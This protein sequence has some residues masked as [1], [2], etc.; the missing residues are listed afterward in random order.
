M[1]LLF[2]L[3][4]THYTAD[5]CFLLL[6]RLLRYLSPIHSCA[7]RLPVFL[8]FLRL[9]CRLYIPDVCF[10]WLHMLLLCRLSICSCAGRLQEL[11]LSRYIHCRFL[12]P[13]PRSLLHLPQGSSMCAPSQE[14]YPEFLPHISIYI[15]YIYTF[16]FPVWCIPADSLSWRLPHLHEQ[17][18]VFHLHPDGSYSL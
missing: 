14:A 16:L 5:V 13:V 17:T 7:L 8:L 12:F 10:L 18:P 11:S 15:T 2:L 3:H 9:H 4:R 6:C 1:S